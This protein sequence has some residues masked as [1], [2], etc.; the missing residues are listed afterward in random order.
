[1]A[2]E[3]SLIS[4]GDHFFSQIPAAVL[5][6]WWLEVK[7]EEKNFVH[8]QIARYWSLRGF[9]VLPACLDPARI[10]PGVWQTNLTAAPKVPSSGCFLGWS[11]YSALNKLNCFLSGTTPCHAKG[12]G[13]FCQ[14]PGVCPL[15]EDEVCQYSGCPEQFCCWVR[16]APATVGKYLQDICEGWLWSIAA[17][18]ICKPCHVVETSSQTRRVRIQGCSIFTVS[19]SCALSLLSCAAENVR[20]WFG[21]MLII[22][23]SALW[24]GSSVSLFLSNTSPQESCSMARTPR[25]YVNTNKK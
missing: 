15:L 20:T 2:H 10:Q 1:M 8:F 22:L 17:V 14:C 3:L 25:Q 19:L 21:Q 18:D 5:S 16:I 24:Q 23:V 9:C 13:P 6:F 4:M 12:T 7:L 11:A